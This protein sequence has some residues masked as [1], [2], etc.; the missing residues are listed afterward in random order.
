[1]R[2]VTGVQTCALPIFFCEIDDFYWFTHVEDEDFAA[3]GE[4]A[5]LNDES[6]CFRDGHEVTGHFWI[7]DGDGAARFNLLF[8][9]RNDA[10]STSEH[11]PKSDCDKFCLTFT[12]HTLHDHFSNPFTCAHDVRWINCFI[13]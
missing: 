7:C 9:E 10:T 3:L 6:A 5:C 1:N 11:I 13:G 4:C 8:K 2:N 12:I